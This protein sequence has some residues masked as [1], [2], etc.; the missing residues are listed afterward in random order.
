M[1]GR[2]SR[3]C[4]GSCPVAISTFDADI[5]AAVVGHHADIIAIASICG[6]PIAVSCAGVRGRRV[7]LVFAH[8]AFGAGIQAAIAA[9]EAEVIA[10]APGLGLLAAASCA[11]V[12]GRWAVAISAF[13]ADI[14]AAVAGGYAD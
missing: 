9:G 6:L 8:F 14:E 1:R 3:V 13:R 4:G 12:R 11:G 10:P 7:G 5:V 2:F